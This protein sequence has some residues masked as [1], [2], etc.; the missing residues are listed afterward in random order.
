MTA[1][2]ETAVQTAPAGNARGYWSTVGR[3]LSRDKVSIACA[4]VLLLIL[5]SAIFAPYLHLADPYQG[6]M[7]RRLKPIGTPNYPLGSD[8]LGRDMLARLIYGGRL[9]LLIGILPVVLAFVL[10]TSLG[11]VAG[12]VGG[13][14]NTAIMRT[15]D[16]FYAFPS[17]LLAIAISGALGAGITNSIVSLTV[18]FLPQITRVA[19]SVTTGVRNMD[20]VEAAR[21]S[22]AGPFTIMRVHMLGNVLGPIFVYA[23]GL[24]SVSMILAAGLS[25]LG[26]GTKPPEP[27]WGLMLNTLRT[28]IYV[29]PWVAAL[30]GAMI[31]AVS[32]CFNLL[33][34]GLRSAMDIRN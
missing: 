4:I 30:P 10:G 9:S 27:E 24:I 13:K 34:D 22:G 6:S 19:E 15:I 18:V 20:F 21:A 17:V 8:E 11:L 14:V 5:L 1:I 33:S 7:I 26:L 23:T 28:A 3:R 12:Y 29:N 31:F 2:T 32:I 16:V 25:F